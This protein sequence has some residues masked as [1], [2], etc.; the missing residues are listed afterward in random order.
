MIFEITRV[1]ARFAGKGSSRTTQQAAFGKTAATAQENMT[2]SGFLRWLAFGSA[3]GEALTVASRDPDSKGKQSS[4]DR[5]S[6]WAFMI[7]AAP[8]FTE[9]VSAIRRQFGF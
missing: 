4:Q 3:D 5:P 9:P 7:D 2:S 1:R 8:A 6:L